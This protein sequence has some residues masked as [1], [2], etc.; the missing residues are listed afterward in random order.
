MGARV[1]WSRKA[2]LDLADIADYIGKDS[3]AAAVRTL[4]KL[5]AAARRLALH[6]LSGHVVPRWNR[7]ALRELVVGSYRLL[8]CVTPD[9]TVVFHV[10]HTRRRIPG[11]FRAEWLRK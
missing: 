3:K 6:P 11:R 8:Y 7:P 1:T 9:E 10:R 5:A 4:R 2:Q